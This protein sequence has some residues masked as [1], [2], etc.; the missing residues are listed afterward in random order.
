MMW[1][2]TGVVK[3]SLDRADVLV[4]CFFS[5]ELWNLIVYRWVNCLQMVGVQRC[6]P[7]NSSGSDE[8]LNDETLNEDSQLP[9]DD[10]HYHAVSTSRDN[11]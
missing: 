9:G 4:S 7:E 1:N 10:L 6:G 3:D 8:I 11:Y 2:I 5:A